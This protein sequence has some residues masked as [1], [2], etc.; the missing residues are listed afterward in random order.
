M[1]EQIRVFPVDGGWAVGASF[2]T[3]PLMFHSGAKAELTA[4]N[5]ASAAAAGGA[6]VLLQIHDSRG[7]LAGERRF[8]PNS[9]RLVAG[10]DVPRRAAR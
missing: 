4:R 3:H 8:G 7:N 6:A 9:L 1:T 5:L 2:C 10:N